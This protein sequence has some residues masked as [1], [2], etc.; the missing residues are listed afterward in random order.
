MVLSSGFRKSRWLELS[1]T[2]T[3]RFS[4]DLRADNIICIGRFAS[5]NNVTILAV[6]TD[7]ITKLKD[8]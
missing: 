4:A 5:V 7:I 6:F 1:P 3:N 8:A 2:P